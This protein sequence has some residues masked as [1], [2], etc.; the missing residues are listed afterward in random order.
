MNL[1]LAALFAGILLSFSV[2]LAQPKIAVYPGSML[3]LEDLYKGQKIEKIVTIK[4]IGSDT[5]RISNVKA[6]CGCTATFMSEK[7]IGPSDSGQLSIIFNTESQLGKVSKQVYISSNDS[8][9]PKLTIQF[10]ANVIEVLKLSPP[11]LLFENGKVDSSYTKTMMISNPSKTTAIKILST[12]VKFDNLKITFMKNSLMPGEE[13]QL[14]AE[15]TAK[16]AGT[17]NGFIQLNTDHPLQ[18]KFEIKVFS[19]INRNK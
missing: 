9:N 15:Y 7:N 16:K 8:S 12:D 5:L 10:S 6:Q 1:K 4:N 19:W 17:F 14:L 13:V 11:T 3:D 2:I 18:K